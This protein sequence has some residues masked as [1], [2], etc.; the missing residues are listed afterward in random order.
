MYSFSD[1][2]KYHYASRKSTWMHWFS[3]PILHTIRQFH[4]WQDRMGKY[5]CERN[6][7]TTQNKCSNVDYRSFNTI[8]KFHSICRK[9]LQ[10]MKIYNYVSI[11]Q[12]YWMFRWSLNMFILLIVS[13]KQ[14][15]YFVSNS[16]W[17]A[18][19][20]IDQIGIYNII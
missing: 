16:T 17:N 7:Q 1:Y 6:F 10:K 13:K 14:L 5:R 19:I 20:L 2:I 3:K 11:V 9:I 12:K 8:S 18:F 4:N 15:L